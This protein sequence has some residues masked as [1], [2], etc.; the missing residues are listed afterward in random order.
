MTHSMETLKT[1][2]KVTFFYSHEEEEEAVADVN[3]YLHPVD[4]IC[5]VDGF[6]LVCIHDLYHAGESEDLVTGQVD[7]MRMIKNLTTPDQFIQSVLR[8]VSEKL[9]NIEQPMTVMLTPEA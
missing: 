1:D 2:V 8:A 5:F 4:S 3:V 7:M 9:I 6:E